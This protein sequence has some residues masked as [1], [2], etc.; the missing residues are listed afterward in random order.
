MEDIL[1][2]TTEHTAPLILASFLRFHPDAELLTLD[3]SHTALRSENILRVL[4]SALPT[5]L[6]SLNL[7][8][9]GL[10]P[11][12]GEKLA[13]LLPLMESVTSHRSSLCHSL[14]QCS[15]GGATTQQRVL[16]RVNVTNYPSTTPSSH[17]TG[18]RQQPRH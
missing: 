2:N 13:V 4:F 16:G 5:S 1:H 11:P 14:V 3:L 6:T 15:A 8:Y 7:S 17:G 18:Y 10:R 12:G 9:T